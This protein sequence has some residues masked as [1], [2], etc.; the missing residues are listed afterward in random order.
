MGIQREAPASS[1]QRSRND[2]QIS[3]NE[4]IPAG[5]MIRAQKE[6]EGH[7]DEKLDKRRPA[8]EGNHLVFIRKTSTRHPP[9]AL[10]LKVLHRCFELGEDVKSVAELMKL[11]Q[12]LTDQ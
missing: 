10:K 8:R 11:Y 3:C 12:Q 1:R 7:A 6:R 5:T 4:Q 9:V 2:L